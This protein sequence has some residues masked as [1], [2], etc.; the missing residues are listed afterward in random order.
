ME[1]QQQSFVSFFVQSYDLLVCSH[2]VSIWNKPSFK[3][4]FFPFRVKERRLFLKDPNGNRNLWCQELS[5]FFQKITICCKKLSFNYA[6]NIHLLIFAVF[7]FQYQSFTIFFDSY[8]YVTETGSC[9]VLFSLKLQ[10]CR[11]YFASPKN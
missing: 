10:C 5:A 6:V 7:E 11:F 1:Y 3:C 8:S 4:D 2:S 9:F